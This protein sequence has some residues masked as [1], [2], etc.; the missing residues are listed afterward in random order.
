M[1]ERQTPDYDAAHDL[2]MEVQDKPRMFRAACSC[3]FT[4]PW[5]TTNVAMG[6]GHRHRAQMRRRTLPIPPASDHP[7][8][9]AR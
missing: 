3:G 6:S 9:V 2:A 8:E 7:D 1:S 4:G 5:E